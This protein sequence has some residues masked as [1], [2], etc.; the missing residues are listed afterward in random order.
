MIVW[1]VDF[2]GFILLCVGS[3][4]AIPRILRL[5]CRIA[6]LYVLIFT[7]CYYFWLTPRFRYFEDHPHFSQT[8]I[9]IAFKFQGFWTLLGNMV[10]LQGM[11]P[12][13]VLFILFFAVKWLSTGIRFD[14]RR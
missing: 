2:I 7:V 14:S 5:F 4:L 8:G 13:A 3:K 9:S 6:I 10:L 1:V 12:L 11:F